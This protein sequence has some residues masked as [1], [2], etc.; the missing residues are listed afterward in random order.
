MAQLGWWSL[1][2]TATSGFVA[3]A[4]GKCSAATRHGDDAVLR[5]W[6][7]CVAVVTGQ[8]AAEG[9]LWWQEERGKG[10]RGKV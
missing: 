10:W 8:R 5:R 4:A 6:L 2:D 3:D 1:D 7:D 9:R